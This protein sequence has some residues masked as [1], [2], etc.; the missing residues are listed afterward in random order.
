MNDSP[1]LSNDLPEEQKTIR[2]K[3]F[4]PGDVFEEFTKEDSEH[5]IPDRFEQQVRKYPERIAIK[6]KTRFLPLAK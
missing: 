1:G 2:A 5:S 6:T 3:C 4:H